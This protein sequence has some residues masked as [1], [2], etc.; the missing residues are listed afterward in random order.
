MGVEQIISAAHR[1]VFNTLPEKPERF[2]GSI[3][4]LSSSVISWIRF[5]LKFFHDFI[6]KN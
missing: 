5:G 3:L 4:I 2:Q 6:D 1:I